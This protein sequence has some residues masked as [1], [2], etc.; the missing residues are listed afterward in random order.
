[1]KLKKQLLLLV[2]AALL[3]AFFWFDLG[4]YLSFESIKSSQSDLNQWYN[5]Q[6]LTFVAGYF[7]VYV[8]ATA[9]SF[10]G[11]VMLT[12]LGGAVFGVAWGTLIVSF[13]SSMGAT[14]AFL[15]ARFLL[16]DR[17]EARFGSRLAEFNEGVQKEGAF[18][19][20]TLRLVPLVPF[21]VINL[22]MGLTQMR[23]W[24][25]YWVSQLGMLAGTAV[26]VN[27]GTQLAQLDSLQGILSPALLGSL[28][29]LG[30]FPLLA[31]RISLALK[32]RQIYARWQHLK[33]KQ[34][35]RNLVVIGAG[36]GGLVTAYIA[37]AVKAKV[38]LVEAHKMGGDCLNYGC[39]P[40]KALIKS[41]QM[42]HNQAHGAR[43]GL[44]DTTPVFSFKAV[45][46][47]INAVVASI[48][49]HDS[50]ERYSALGVEVLSGHARIVNPWTVEIIQPQTGGQAPLVQR[51][52]TRAIVIAAGARP[53]VPPLPGLQ[54]VGFLTSDTLWEAF[55]QLDALP[56]RLLVLGGGPIGCELAQSFARLGAAVTL[57]EMAPRLLMGEDADAA[58]VVAASLQAD[59]VRLLN[60]HRAV[61][62]EPLAGA[63][64]AKPGASF[65]PGT[66][67]LEQVDTQAGTQTDTPAATPV[68]VEFDALLCAVGRS[69]RLTGYGLED[70]GI[71]TTKTVQTNDYL[72]TLYPN[73]YAAGDVAGPYQLTH[74]AAHQAW[75]A[76]VNA[77]FGGFKKF[78]VDYRVIPRATFTD[79][80]VARV[81]LNEQEARAK[82]T[83]FEVTKFALSDLDRAL[84]DSQTQ[85]F[86]KV[87]TVPGKDTILG[88]TIVGHHAGDLLAEYVLAM[89][90]GLGLSKILGT[91][92]TYPTLSEANKY[93]AGEWKRAHAPQQLLKWA[94][95]YHTWKRG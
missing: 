24:T 38:T 94:A 1:M 62:C 46:Q 21:F 11:A 36:A 22:L 51:L 95:K 59:G 27:A 39:V 44:Q 50:V 17:L 57:V 26:Y 42:A 69:A 12:L 58:E 75:Y 8:L 19:L 29:L 73:I 32:K 91:I 28:V 47:R 23:T 18:Y 84:A 86:V 56:Q 49:P 41:A 6:P 40:S 30:L 35:D 71:A 2:L 43:Y 79:P 83:A 65:G 10:P 74:V 25:Y 9:L 68:L 31:R 16:R 3:A 4:R 85:G 34:F 66:L 64:T 37:A 82:H 76:A 13:A 14:L 33:P 89:K 54:E 5:A 81:G 55:A 80:E 52:S 72:E 15:A 78:K 77:L 53:T 90:H 20:F 92:H 60:H 70:L 45:M 7:A 48:A 87:L 61:R 88:V 63:N 67:V 93:A